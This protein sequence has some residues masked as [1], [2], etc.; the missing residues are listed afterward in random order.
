MSS[1]KL[2]DPPEQG[3]NRH[4][5]IPIVGRLQRAFSEGR[6]STGPPRTADATG[7]T[8]RGLTT[9]EEGLGGAGMNASAIPRTWTEKDHFRAGLRSISTAPRIASGTDVDLT[10]LMA[11]GTLSLDRS[12]LIRIAAQQPYCLYA[13]I[14]NSAVRTRPDRKQGDHITPRLLDWSATSSG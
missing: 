12:R 14:L 8:S 4:L 2:S 10:D 3:L 1:A 7:E 13:G 5:F 6:R 9:S 11:K